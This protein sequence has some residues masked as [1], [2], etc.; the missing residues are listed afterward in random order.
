MLEDDGRG[1]TLISR[2]P[3]EVHKEDVKHAMRPSARPNAACETS[4]GVLGF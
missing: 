3:D 2:E 1:L 4:D